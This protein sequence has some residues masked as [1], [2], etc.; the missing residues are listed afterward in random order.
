MDEDFDSDE[1]EDENEEEDEDGRTDNHQRLNRLNSSIEKRHKSRATNARE[2]LASPSPNKP[3]E[4]QLQRSKVNTF[5]SQYSDKRSHRSSSLD[6][7][8]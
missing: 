7:R 2:L 6:H 3:G 1:E 5:E 4:G 8:N